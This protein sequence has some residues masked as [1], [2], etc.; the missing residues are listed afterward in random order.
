MTDPL[1]TALY[2]ND[3]TASTTAR[4]RRLNDFD[5]PL[6]LAQQWAAA[7]GVDA[8]ATSIT[9]EGC[10]AGADPS[11]YAKTLVLQ[12]SQNGDIPVS[13]ISM[14]ITPNSREVAHFLFIFF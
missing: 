3:V 8:P 9:N 4:L 7:A 14:P 1:E 6:V 13:L 11:G 2:I 12:E 5:C 10:P